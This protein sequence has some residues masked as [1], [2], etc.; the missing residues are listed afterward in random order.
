MWD[1]SNL[2]RT[3]YFATEEFSD[4]TFAVVN[5]LLYTL[6]AEQHSVATDQAVRD[7]YNSY[8][9]LCQANLETILANLPLFLSAKTEN[10]QALLLGV[11]FVLFGLN[12]CI[13]NL[14]LRICLC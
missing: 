10:V 6:F 14:S 11:G 3:V 5:G 9:Q 8:V 2:C 13:F 4:A 7:E 12:C 1:F